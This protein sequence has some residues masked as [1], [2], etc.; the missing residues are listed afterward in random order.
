MPY[1]H[2]GF[3]K[4]GGSNGESLFKKKK[5]EYFVFKCSVSY[6]LTHSFHFVSDVCVVAFKI[7]DKS[8]VSDP[9]SGCLIEPGSRIRNIFFSGSRAGSQT[10]IFDC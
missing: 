4:P 3:S 9:G 6:I 10:L 2:I 8:S 7:I 1:N 5:S